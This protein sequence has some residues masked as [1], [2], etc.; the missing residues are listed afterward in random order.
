[1]EAMLS[2]Y[3]DFAQGAKAGEI[4]TVDLSG[5]V[6]EVA[7]FHGLEADAP[8]GVMLEGRRPQLK[9]A[10]DNLVG[11]ALKYAGPP[12][13]A[14]EATETHALIHVDDDGPGIAEARRAD[15]LRP[16]ARLD[17]ARSQ[18]VEG[19][20]LGLSVTRDI[21]QIHGGRLKLED[22]PRGGLRATLQLPL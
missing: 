21:A 5:L 15:A 18:N 19:I 11:N 6:R 20:G 22:S 16:F 4:G 7:S 2:G 8:D 1:M 9:R 13:L 17:A 12:T 14:L 3:L 10:L